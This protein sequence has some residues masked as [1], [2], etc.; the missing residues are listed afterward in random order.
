TCVV[1]GGEAEC[2]CE[3]GWG[4]TD[5]NQCIN[6]ATEATAFEFV[7]GWPSSKDTCSTRVELSVSRMTLRSREGDSPVYL[8]AGSSFSG[9]V[10]QHVQVEAGPTK[11]AELVFFHPVVLMS[12]D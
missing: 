8:C 5:C 7:T 10:N 6:L 2:H 12:L 3:P 1:V 4:G 11:A 9:L